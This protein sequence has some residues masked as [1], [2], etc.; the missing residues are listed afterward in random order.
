[1]NT[2]VVKKKSHKRKYEGDENQHLHYSKSQKLVRE[3]NRKAKL[4]KNPAMSIFEAGRERTKR[5]VKK[6]Y[7]NINLNKPPSSIA[8]LSNY[9][10]RNKK[11]EDKSNK[12]DKDHKSTV[13]KH[14]TFRLPIREPSAQNFDMYYYLAP[15]RE[16]A[17]VTNILELYDEAKNRL[18][19]KKK[20]LKSGLKPSEDKLT[21]KDN[22]LK[23]KENDINISNNKSNVLGASNKAN[24][25]N[26]E[27]NSDLSKTKKNKENKGILTKSNMNS[28]NILKPSTKTNKLSKTKDGKSNCIKTEIDDNKENIPPLHHNQCNTTMNLQFIDY[29][30]T[31]AT[32]VGLTS[33]TKASNREEEKSTTKLA[34]VKKE[35]QNISESKPQQQKKN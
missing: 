33:V 25:L 35:D 20:A 27:N 30:S 12:N 8:S 7:P 9:T 19:Q 15:N 32:T 18:I 10:P 4:R 22:I 24:L 28:S 13:Y 17:T 23:D 34:K 21:S 3:R 16:P 29:P 6:E 26:K 1:M 11:N 5:I 2:Q 31:G 14:T